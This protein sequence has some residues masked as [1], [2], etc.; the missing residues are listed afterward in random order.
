[1]QTDDHCLGFPDD[2]IGCIQYC[3]PEFAISLAWMG[4]LRIKPRRYFNGTYLHYDLQTAE[5]V[6][7]A[8]E[9]K[10]RSKTRSFA[11]L[12]IHHFIHI[13]TILCDWLV[14]SF[15]NLYI[16]YF[17]DLHLFTAFG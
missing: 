10:I 15:T 9:L 12:H 17:T 13:F 2:S 11:V 3:S 4:L 6:E 5:K 1:M 8:K 7:A 16:G 14:I